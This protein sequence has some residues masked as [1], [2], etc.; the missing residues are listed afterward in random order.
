MI[1][2]VVA[3]AGCSFAGGYF[4]ASS[5]AVEDWRALW[6][7]RERRAIAQFMNAEGFRFRRPLVGARSRI[8]PLLRLKAWGAVLCG[9]CFGWHVA[10][11]VLVLQAIVAA[12]LGSPSVVTASEAPIVWA[13]ACGLHTALFTLAGKVGLFNE[14]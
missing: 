13:A 6:Q 12:K 2:A 8:W 9:I 11:A 4:M 14:E 3:V 7:A 1:D 5:A 10:W